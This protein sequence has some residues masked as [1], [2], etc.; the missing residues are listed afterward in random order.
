MIQG[1]VNAAY[2]PVISL[3]VQ[4]PSGKSGEMEAVV[5]TGFNGYLTLPSESVATL[6][7]L[8]S[9]RATAILADG[10]E[11]AFDLYRTTVLWDGHPRHV[12]A[13]MS[14]AV[15]LVGMQL[16]DRYSLFIEVERSGRVLIQARK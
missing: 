2:E 14:D 8:R 10:S 4:G 5:D 15:P 12:D 13:Y 11:E 7:L 9:A 1:V 6:G 3:T 16:L